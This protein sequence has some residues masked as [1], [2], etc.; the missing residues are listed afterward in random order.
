MHSP[1]FTI[2][3]TP[4]LASTA[5]VLENCKVAG[6]LRRAVRQGSGESLA[7]SLTQRLLSNTNVSIFRAPNVDRDRMSSAFRLG[8]S[9]ELQLGSADDGPWILGGRH[10]A[11]AC[12]LFLPQQDFAVLL[13]PRARRSARKPIQFFPSA[14]RSDRIGIYTSLHRALPSRFDCAASGMTAYRQ[15][16]PMSFHQCLFFTKPTVCSRRRPASSRSVALLFAA[17]MVSLVHAQDAAPAD[18]N[19]VNTRMVPGDMKADSPVTFPERGALPS[20]YSPDVKTQSKPTEKNYYLFSSPCRSLKQIDA[21]QAEMPRGQFSIPDNDWT[22]L[23]KTQRALTEGGKLQILGLGDSIINDTMR[24]GWIAKLQ[25]AYPKAEI[26]ATVYVRGGGGCQHYKVEDRIAKNVIPL[27]PDLVLIG[28]ISQQDVA[29][30]EEV[31]RQLR[32]DLPDV[33]I[34]LTSGVFGTTD[35]RDEA[36]LAKARHSGSSEY[37]RSLK[38][39]AAKHHCAYLDMTTPWAEYIR[40][41]KLH[42]HRFYR[43]VVHANA[44]GEQILSMI[45]M[46]FFAKPAESK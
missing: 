17:C 10:T 19:A 27:K 36:A 8:V 22:C 6:T 33:E 26:A 25:Q 15:R 43:D 37:G 28:G 31:I 29:S 41:T 3:R 24:S 5:R 13:S 16:S 34:L 7:F 23:E 9:R 32:A 4:T 18:R 12:Y 20:K 40:S 44:E 30:I 21:I 2:N 45:L 11:C 35:P 38:S 42:P 14:S 39:L 1:Q 46:S